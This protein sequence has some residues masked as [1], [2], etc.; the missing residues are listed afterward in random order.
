MKLYLSSYHIPTPRD[1][2]A[3]IGKPAVDTKVGLI[4]NAQDHR[5]DATR[6]TKVHETVTYLASLGFGAVTSIDL[7]DFDDQNVLEETL[8]QYDLLWAVGGNAFRL[9]HAMRV[10][11]FD[12][13]IRNVLERGVV[14]GGDSAGAAVV[15]NSL[16][17][18]ELVDGSD[19]G[20]I[21]WDGV[22]LID[23]YI[24]PHVGSPDV[25]ELIN[26]VI[27]LHKDDPTTVKLND[28]EALVVDGVDETIVISATPFYS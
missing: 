28:F 4:T 24:I 17:G 27:E 12:A 9:R 15:G 26:Q 16:K 6:R 7:R 25:A 8:R 23:H 22:S 14:Y 21:I 20:E 5:D 1:L 19:T 18:I 10:S 3:L 2:Q 13:V 11:G